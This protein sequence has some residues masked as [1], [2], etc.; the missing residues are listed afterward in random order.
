MEL[1]FLCRYYYFTLEEAILKKIKKQ[2]RFPE[3]EVLYITRTLLSVY[4][5]LHQYDQCNTSIFR[6]S[7]IFLTPEGFLKFYPEIND[8]QK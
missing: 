3:E 1:S 5:S 8:W 7:K 6:S 4:E 2:S